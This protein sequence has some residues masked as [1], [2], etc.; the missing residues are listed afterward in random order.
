M[1]REQVGVEHLAAVVGE[2]AEIFLA[3]GVQRFVH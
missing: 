3:E 1:S 2:L